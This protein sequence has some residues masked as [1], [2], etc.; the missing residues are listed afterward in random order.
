MKWTRSLNGR[1]MGACFLCKRYVEEE[2]C[3]PVE[4]HYACTNPGCAAHFRLFL[5]HPTVGKN[6]GVFACLIMALGAIVQ[7]GMSSFLH[8]ELYGSCPVCEQPFVDRGDGVLLCSKGGCGV[9]VEFYLEE[10]QLSFAALTIIM[11]VPEPGF[12]KILSEDTGS[13]R[14]N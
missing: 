12:S 11:R 1:W 5:S 2:I 10:L 9:S 3:S 6:R 14:Y 8:D 4:R 7:E 13:S